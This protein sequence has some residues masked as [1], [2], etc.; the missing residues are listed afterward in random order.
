[1]P[2]LAAALAAALA[3]CEK[4]TG[5]A[6][7]GYAFPRENQ[8]AALVA[9]ARL[10]TDTTNGSIR[11]VGDWDSGGTEATVELARAHRLVALP[12]VVGVVGHAASRGTLVAAPVYLDAGI[13]LVVPTASSSRL[14]DIGKWIFPMAPGDSVEAEFLGHVALDRMHASR[15]AIYF[16]D[17]P[18]GSGIRWEMRAYLARRGVSLVDQV[19]F[20]D[21]ADLPTL[22]EASLAR[23]HPDLVV[24]V[25]RQVE[26]A[27]LAA[28]IYDHDPSI[29]LLAADGAL[30]QVASLIV[31]AGA[32][33][34][35]LFLTS[36][37]VPDTTDSLQR[38][39]I[40]QYRLDSGREPL[41]FDAMRYDAIMVLA[42]AIREVGP[43]RAA[44][45]DWLWSL[46]GSRPAYR[47]VTG[48]ISF[49]PGARH[50]LYLV[51]LQDGAP[52][53][54]PDSGVLR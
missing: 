1:V 29:H 43:D 31:T 36:F 40:S 13:P 21:G 23:S 20:V 7:I 44:I 18:Y 19:P 6:V 27:R 11:I 33:S 9:A 39:F 41:S 50:H 32:A 25:G 22:V 42:E 30:D 14:W 8:Q 35:S 54:V 52:V 15:L 49:R 4:P 38:A 51:R 17:N 26:V 2:R 16:A 37:W 48:D 24:L 28:L 10:P 5:A 12:R 34:D 53:V 47:G 45:R 3:A 46:G